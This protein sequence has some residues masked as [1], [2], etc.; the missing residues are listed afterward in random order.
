MDQYVTGAT[1]K[2]L[3]EKQNMTQADLAAKLNVSDKAVSKWETGRGYPDITFLEPLAKVLGI[4]I[5]ELLSGNDIVNTNK[6]S[7]INKTNLY[8]CPIC[9]NIISSTGEALVS[10]CGITLPALEAE[11]A[12]EAHMIQVEESDGE[13]YVTVDHEMSKTHYIS[14]LA[15]MG[16]DCLKMVKM[17]PEWN[18]Q[19]RFQVRGRGRLYAFCN[20]H[21]LFYTDVRPMRKTPV[22]KVG[23]MP[24]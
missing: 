18:C 21:G 11:K 10:C 4:S 13:Y 7:N 24:V 12:D 17:Y 3:R 14:F 16:D 20:H 6:G 15:F 1:I 8:V 2:R 22:R 5:I 9:G 23:E 19:A